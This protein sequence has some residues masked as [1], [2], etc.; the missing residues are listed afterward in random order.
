MYF[1]YILKLRNGQHYVGFTRDLKKRFDRH[2]NHSS[3]TTSRIEPEELVFFSAFKTKEKALNFEKYMK[4]SSGFA[5]RNKRLI[6]IYRES[7][8]AHHSASSADY[9]V[10]TP[11]NNTS[12]AARRSFERSEK[13]RRLSLPTISSA[14]NFKFLCNPT[15][16]SGRSGYRALSS[17]RSYPAGHSLRPYPH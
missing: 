5:F 17:I 3:P 15:H 9:A 10:I 2:M 7:L 8:P 14:R 13:R 12:E 4:S 11:C 1:V 16:P 6:I